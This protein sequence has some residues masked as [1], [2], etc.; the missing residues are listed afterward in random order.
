MPCDTAPSGRSNRRT[1]AEPERT[2]GAVTG[3]VRILRT[4]VIRTR[5]ISMLMAAEMQRLEVVRGH[6]EFLS[7]FSGRRVGGRCSVAWAAGGIGWLRVQTEQ[8][9]TMLAMA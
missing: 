2:G 4:Y 7:H 8:V 3:W 6:S 1:V 9:Q 5:L